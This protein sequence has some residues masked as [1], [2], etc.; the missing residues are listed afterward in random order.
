ME[1]YGFI[2]IWFDK[3]R[4]MF[5]IGCHWGTEDDG[6][7]C[8]SNRM[9]DAY[10]RRPQD[11]KRRVVSRLYTNRVSLLEEEYKWLSLIKSEELGTKYYNLYNRHF[12]HWTNNPSVYMST[13]EKIKEKKKGQKITQSQYDALIKHRA[14][15]GNKSKTGQKDSIETIEKRRQKMLGH[16]V[17]DETKEKIRLKQT[18]KK[19]T[20]ET[21][22]K[23]R[24]AM[25][26]YYKK[27]KNQ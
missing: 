13:I 27:K 2:Y 19:Q 11:F 24:Q 4:K 26:E 3:K 15:W 5:Y 21:R 10:R 12:G 23:K 18:G 6:Y 8:S 17:T 16:V 22:E 14:S 7:I 1:K 9:R 25:L 20:N